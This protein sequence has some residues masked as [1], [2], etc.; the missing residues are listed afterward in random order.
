MSAEQIT[1]L[2]HFIS[3]EEENLITSMANLKED[4]FL[5][6]NLDSLF[7]D[8]SKLKPLDD[9]NL[10]IPAFLYLI[11]HNE[12]CISMTSL[13]RRHYSKSFLSLRLAIDSALTAYYLLKKPDKISI[14]L[15]G[16]ENILSKEK[17]KEWYRIFFNTKRTIK[18]DIDN[19]PLAEKLIE[20]HE[21]CSL[22]AHSDPC[23]ILHKYN[24]DKVNM[25]LEAKYF[26]YESNPGD[27]HR[28]LEFL[29]NEFFRILLIFW[30]E[31]FKKR[32]DDKFAIINTQID[33]FKKNMDIFVNKRIA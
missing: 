31:M 2:I 25:K 18:Q 28:N 9:N 24:L 10:K 8:C 32:A 26:D 1:G 6:S 16:V 19:F 3:I 5:I 23:G 27:D 15:S 30:H 22:Y 11:T 20:A 33:M 12:F 17:N 13:L 7:R 4:F 14:Y 29:L 21:H